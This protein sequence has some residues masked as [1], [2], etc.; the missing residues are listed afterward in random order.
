MPLATASG[1]MF[2]RPN[3][4][5]L[6]G[7]VFILNWESVKGSASSL[8][9]NRTAEKTSLIPT[10]FASSLKKLNGLLSD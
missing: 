3:V 7:G 1:K 10:Y 8:T 4:N 6:S 5:L 2:P 9:G